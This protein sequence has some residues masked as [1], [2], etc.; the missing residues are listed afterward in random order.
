MSAPARPGP[1]LARR[2][3]HRQGFP[4]LLSLYMELLRSALRKGKLPKKL[5]GH[6]EV[7]V[8]A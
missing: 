3:P 2:P 7:K 1:P 4:G 6:K 5:T 8:R